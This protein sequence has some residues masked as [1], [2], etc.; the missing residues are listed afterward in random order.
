MNIL[1][2]KFY[3]QDPVATARTLLGKYVVRTVSGGV[4]TG[5]IVE[6][7]AYREDDPASHSFRGV[8]KRSA[9]MFGPGGIAYVY[10][11]YGM[12]D[13]FNVVT[14]PEGYGGAVLV[15]AL[16]PGDGIRR[17]WKNR[18]PDRP[19]DDR[20]INELCSGPGKL[21]RALN[22]KTGE[23]NGKSFLTSDLQIMEKNNEEQ[24][25]I[26]SATRI[27]IN[28]SAEKQWR[29]YIRNSRFISRP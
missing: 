25:S 16:E 6:T 24:F 17:M 11:I 10:F 19:F 8:T 18:F 14:G 5:R 23:E 1:P 2:Q 22:I 27:G 21:C 9:V 4:L 20:K 15:R 28:R 7:E 26:V 29:F 3:I 13:C 12:Y